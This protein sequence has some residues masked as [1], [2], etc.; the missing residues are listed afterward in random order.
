LISSDWKD[1]GGDDILY[2]ELQWDKSTGGVEWA[3]LT[4]YTPDE[5][6]K[7][8]FKH[9]VDSPFESGTMQKYRVRAMNGV[10]L[11]IFSDILEI[12]ADKVPQYMNVP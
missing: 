11:G 3:T 12:Q 5:E 10:G 4:T 8:S 1:T 6:V 2:Y 9:I 7:L